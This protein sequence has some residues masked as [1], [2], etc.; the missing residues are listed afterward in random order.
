VDLLATHEGEAARSDDVALLAGR[1][2]A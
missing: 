2:A 1:R